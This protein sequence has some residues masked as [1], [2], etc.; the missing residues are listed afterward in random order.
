MKPFGLTATALAATIP[1]LAVVRSLKKKT[2]SKSGAISAWCVGFLIVGSGLRGFVLLM[3]YQVRN[4]HRKSV[5]DIENI[6][7]YHWISRFIVSKLVSDIFAS[8]QIASSATKHKKEWKEAHD[9]TAAEASVRG[10]AQVLGCSALAVLLSL[11]HVVRVGDEKAIDYGDDYL[12]ASLTC[13]ILAHHATCLADT[14]ASELGI[15]NKK[16]PVLLTQPWRTVPPGTNGGITWWGTGMSAV[17]GALM[18]LGMAWMDWCSGIIPVQ[19]DKLLLMGTVCGLVG[20]FVDSL[21][22]ATLQATYQDPETRVIHHEAKAK[23]N[24]KLISGANILTNV[25]VNLVS[26]C[27]TSALGGLVFGPWIFGSQ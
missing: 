3:F 26:I 1:T 20:S 19:N 6:L 10:P 7:Q 27:I 16:P 17:G 22:G 2:L 9:A 13:A 14:L 15:L 4:R 21:L 23:A 8:P 25:Q 18:G 12:A 24:F 11:I 5:L